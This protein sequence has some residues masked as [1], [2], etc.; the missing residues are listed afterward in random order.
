VSSST[1]RYYADGNDHHILY[2]GQKLLYLLHPARVGK[3][4]GIVAGLDDM[5]VLDCR[6]YMVD[7]DYLDDAVGLG[8]LVL[9]GTG[10]LAGPDY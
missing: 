1:G 9:D 3:E 2:C 7:L 5:V 6:E 10:V 4:S 8:S